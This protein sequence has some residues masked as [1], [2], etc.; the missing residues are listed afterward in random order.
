MTLPSLED[1]TLVMVFCYFCIIVIWLGV[2]AIL[3]LDQVLDLNLDWIPFPV[4]NRPFVALIAYVMLL[5]SLVRCWIL[6]VRL[7]AQ[8][9]HREQMRRRPTPPKV[10]NPSLRFAEEPDPEQDK[11]SDI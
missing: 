1:E 5:Y 7:R 4:A 11:G 10:V 3:V 8:D 6:W 2:A 9:K